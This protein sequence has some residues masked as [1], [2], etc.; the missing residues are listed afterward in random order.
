MLGNEAFD[1]EEMIKA[2]REATL[3]RMADYGGTILAVPDTT[4]VNYNTRI[5][6]EGIGYIGGKTM[7]VNVHSCLAV[8]GDGLVL[9]I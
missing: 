5:K 8:T 3:R 6:T 4:G 9:G 7:G 1:R 2:R